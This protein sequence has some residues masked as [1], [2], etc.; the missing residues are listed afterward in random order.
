MFISE[1]DRA[2]LSRLLA[3]PIRLRA[4]YETNSNDRVRMKNVEGIRADKG[5]M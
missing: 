5:V 3:L 1:T 4:V 2:I